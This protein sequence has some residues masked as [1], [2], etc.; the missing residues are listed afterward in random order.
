[1]NA[2]VLKGRIIYI[3]WLSGPHAKDNAEG[4]NGGLLAFVALRRAIRP[5]RA[6]EYPE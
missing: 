1:M 5:P 6:N 4:G 2:C 3:V